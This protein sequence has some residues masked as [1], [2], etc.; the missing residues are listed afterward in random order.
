MKGINETKTSH[1]QYLDLAEET[2]DIATRKSPH[3]L[4]PTFKLRGWVVSFKYSR[5]SDLNSMK[6]NFSGLTLNNHL[7]APGCIRAS[8]DQENTW[9]L[10]SGLNILQTNNISDLL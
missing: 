8:N 5:N 7:F 3:F 9:F 6:F 1:V 2:A 10:N 4:L